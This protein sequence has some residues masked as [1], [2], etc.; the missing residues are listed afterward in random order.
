MV[1]AATAS[2]LAGFALD[3]GATVFAAAAHHAVG[4]AA[5]AIGLALDATGLAFAIAPITTSLDAVFAIAAAA[6]VCL[7]LATPITALASVAVV[8][9]LAAGALPLLANAPGGAAFAADFRR[10]RAAAALHCLHSDWRPV[11]LLAAPKPE[12]GRTTP[13]PLHTWHRTADSCETCI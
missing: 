1:S 11:R 3:A 6:D 8:S 12:A 4:A 10:A 7:A 2:A 13:Q 9:T 5:T